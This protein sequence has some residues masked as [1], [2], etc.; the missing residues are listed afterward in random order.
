[1]FENNPYQFL[2]NLF[3]ILVI[4]RFG[5]TSTMHTGDSCSGILDAILTL[6]GICLEIHGSWFVFD[7]VLS[8][9]FLNI[10]F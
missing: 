3:I 10:A 9:T 6:T 5:E 7:L 1:M 4:N 8:V 2:A